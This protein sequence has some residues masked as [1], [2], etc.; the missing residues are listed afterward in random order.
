[1]RSK[2]SVRKSERH[3]VDAEVTASCSVNSHA[4]AVN[5]WAVSAVAMA[6]KSSPSRT[7]V[8]ILLVI[9]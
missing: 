3:A 7:R 5:G 1:M 2:S 4:P 6:K 9:E 8:T